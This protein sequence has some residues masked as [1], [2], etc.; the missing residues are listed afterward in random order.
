MHSLST[1]LLL[2]CPQV[3]RL[4]KKTGFQIWCSLSGVVEDSDTVRNTL[5]LGKQFLASS[6][7]LWLLHP[8]DRH[9]TV[10]PSTGN[11]SQQESVKSWKT[12]LLSSTTVGTQNLAEQSVS[13]K[14]H[15]IQNIHA[16]WA[17]TTSWSGTYLCCLHHMVRVVVFH[18]WQFSHVSTALIDAQR[19]LPRPFACPCN[20]KLQMLQRG[21]GFK[22]HRST[23]C[24][25]PSR[26]YAVPPYVLDTN[27]YICLQTYNST[28]VHIRLPTHTHTHTHTSVIYSP[29]MTISSTSMNTCW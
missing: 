16:M 17:R 12:W 21:H 13:T 14:L 23:H 25:F 28:Y 20:T 3:F 29:Q 22:P 7:P 11:H 18:W 24:M 9:N 5:S 26:S 2:S 27:R 4:T 10:H 1:S 19:K 15:E 8:E 6:I